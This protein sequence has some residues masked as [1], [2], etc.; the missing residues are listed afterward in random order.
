MRPTVFIL[1]VL[2]LSL[3]IHASTARV[4]HVS[5]GDSFIIESGERVRMIGV[6]A[7][8]LTD[9]F[10]AEAKSH[11]A[12]LIRGKTV[13]LERDPQNQDR[14][15]HG[16]L[17]RFVALNG[18][19]I[20]R[21]MIVDGFAYALLRYPFARERCDAY[22]EAE[23][24]AR[25]ARLGIWAEQ[26]R[27]GPPAAASKTSP[28]ATDRES[29]RIGDDGDSFWPEIRWIILAAILIA[30]LIFATRLLRR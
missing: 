22:R 25:S 2:T 9:P 3:V 23:R 19:D 6:D 13:T 18:A 11:L 12:E 7:P 30:V 20:N 10:G 17:L 27:P 26:P 14:D 1:A 5:D 29:G 8:E 4:R 21:Q 16:R 15:V 28:A 24:V